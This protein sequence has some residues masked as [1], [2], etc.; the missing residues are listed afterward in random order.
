MYG[1]AVHEYFARSLKQR[2]HVSEVSILFYEV[3]KVSLPLIR[4]IIIL[5]GNLLVPSP[6][7]QCSRD[8]QGKAV[9]STST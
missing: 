7:K 2:S 4:C 8:G 5:F 1:L 9:I 3:T 6:A